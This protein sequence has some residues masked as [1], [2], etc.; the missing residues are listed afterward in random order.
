MAEERGEDP[1]VGR[2]IARKYVLESCVGRGG[3]ASV[4]RARQEPLG[5]PVAIKILHD[6]YLDDPTFAGR[7]KREAKSVSRL[8]HPNL[9]QV[10]DFGEE[11]DGRL[12]MAMEYLEG[13]NLHTVIRTQGPLSRET[14]VDVLSQALAALAV[15]HEGGVVHRDLKPHNLMVSQGRDD[16]G[17]EKR[18]VKL[19]DFGFVK[20]IEVK[21]EQ[22]GSTTTVTLTKHGR[23]IGTPEYMSPEQVRSE[24][25]DAR[26]DIYSMGIILYEMLTGRV[27]FRAKGFV[28]LAIMQVDALP[29]KPS[30][31]AEDVDP[32]LESVCLRALEKKPEAR[33]SSARQMRSALRVAIGIRD[34]NASTPPPPMPA[35]ANAGTSPTEKAQSEPPPPAPGMPPPKPS[36]LPVMIGVLIAVAGIAI[37]LFVR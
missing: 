24:E 31:M 2:T 33:F 11:P 3:I 19:C 34:A 8:T 14:I 27:P 1:L 9:V 7:F 5:R 22:V 13:D 36:Y 15:A 23:V 20:N 30:T 21:T 4:Y 17:N 6:S 12:Y 35:L 16:E 18:I 32:E 37:A 28:N 26:S 25:L 10:F 29:P